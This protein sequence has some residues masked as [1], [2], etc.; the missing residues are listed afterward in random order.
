MAGGQTLRAPRVTP[1]S[2]SPHQE[3]VPWLHRIAPGQ[4]GDQRT[5]P[6][7]SEKRHRL[8]HLQIVRPVSHKRLFSFG[9]VKNHG[10]MRGEAF[11]QLAGGLFLLPCAL[12]QHAAVKKP[13][14]SQ[15]HSQ[16]LHTKTTFCDRAMC[17][18]TGITSPFLPSLPCLLFFFFSPGYQVHQR[19]SDQYKTALSVKTI[20]Y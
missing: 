13:P 1:A 20:P 2:V 17:Y 8:L 16:Q 19:D 6:H 3:Q 7:A 4:D 15:N 9:N 10:E 18:S 11:L 12:G 5:P 14:H